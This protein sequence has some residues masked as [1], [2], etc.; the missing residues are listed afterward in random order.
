MLERLP[1]ESL[2]LAFRLKTLHSLYHSKTATFGTGGSVKMCFAS[3]LLQGRNSKNE[4]RR[5]ITFA[6][7][8]FL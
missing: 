1:K 8:N 5:N 7:F 3:W 4:N 6:S 2:Y